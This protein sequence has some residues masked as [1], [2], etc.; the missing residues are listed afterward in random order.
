[1]N[2]RAKNLIILH[3]DEL[4][5]DALGFMGNPDCKTPN[6]DRFAQRSTVFNRHFSVSAKCVPSRCAMMTGRYAHADGIRTVNETNLL[7]PNRPNLLRRLSLAGYETAVFGIN[8][9]WENFYGDNNRKSS[10]VVDYQSFEPND[11]K[12]LLSKSWKVQ[13]PTEES[14]SI[15]VNGG[16][17]NLEVYRRTKPLEY[18]CD[19]NRAEQAVHYLENVRD[20]SR[21]FFMQLNISAPHPLYE[22][23][24]P[25]FSM[26]DREAIKAYPHELPE[27]PPLCIEK[28]R[29]I[30]AG[31]HASEA[32]FRQIQAVYY[33]MVTKVDELMG[34][35]L[36]VIEKQGLL[37][38]TVVVFTSDH[39]DFAGQY[40]LPEKWD[41][42]MQDCLLHVPFVM[43]VPGM[44][45]GRRIESMSEHVDFTPTVLELLGLDGDWNIQGESL[46]PIIAGEKRKEAVFADGGHE[47]PMRERFNV[48]LTEAH[49]GI[50]RPATQGKQE[51]YSKYPDTMARTRMIRTDR[52]KLIMRETN[53]SEL[54][55]LENDP[56]ELSNL[57]NRPGLE[58]VSHDLLVKLLRWSIRTAPEG[59]YQEDV[60]A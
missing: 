7:P 34:R 6:L 39:G 15:T 5:A 12:P 18:F 53:D 49:D 2:R 1:M 43:H 54:Y 20:R 14:R 44:E 47:A 45:E 21:P 51:T 46:L 38:D 11:F 31:K 27:N 17:V 26:Y 37:D 16:A 29:E 48:P 22:V 57:W 10:G 30:R 13:Q 24:E 4:R 36:D 41:T 19:D 60:G 23:E 59:R 32:D 52:W 33:G 28:M 40:G 3:S 9:V 8:H 56:D 42:A 35:V 55:D 25:Y 50:E 58:A